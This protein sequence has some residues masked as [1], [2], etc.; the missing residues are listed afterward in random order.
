MDVY[1]A[2][3]LVSKI[4]IVLVQFSHSKNWE[5]KKK[6][7]TKRYIDSIFW[8][9]IRFSSL[10]KIQITL[11]L[12][13]ETAQEGKKDHKYLNNWDDQKNPYLGLQ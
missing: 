7:C 5:R 2:I 3:V 4:K 1:K 9:V 8:Y 13:E 11:N 6:R 12:E 10:Q